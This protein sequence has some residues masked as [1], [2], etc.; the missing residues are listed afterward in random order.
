MRRPRWSGTC[1][2]ISTGM[3]AGIRR[4]QPARSSGPRRPTRSA[5]SAASSSRT[6][7]SCASNC[8]RCPIS[9]RPSAIACS[10]RRSRCSTTW[11]M[12]VCFPSPMETAPSGNGNRGSRRGPTIGKTSRRWWRNRSIRRDSRPS[13]ATSRRP[14]E[15]GG[16]PMPVTVRTFA[17]SG[18]AAAALSSD[19]GARY[20]GG[21]TL[22]M[23]ALNEG[24]VPISNVVRVQNSN[25]KQNRAPGGRVT[26]G[27]GVTLA[28]ILAERELAF[29]HATA[30]SIGG[31]AVRNMGT[32]GG[33]LFAP[34]PYGDFTVALLALDAVV[35]VQGG[36][37]SRA[38]PIEEF[39]QSR[40][41]QTDTLVLSVSCQKPGSAEA[42]RYRKI[43][44]IKPKGGSVIPLAPHLPMS[45]G[46][47]VGARI[48]LGSMAP[49]QIRARAAERAL[50]GRSLDAS[51][52]GAAA[53]A[54][55]EGTSPGDSALASAW[56]QREIV[57][58]H[59]RRLLSGQE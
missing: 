3:I 13:A 32:V 34:N 20:L 22:V 59:L 38:V 25:L 10:I 6:A 9:S 41:R 26:I 49:T 48:A 46:R 18:E 24:D 17:S 43:A 12:S 15:R 35:S 31:P 40:E 47:I 7:R 23:R 16:K 44:R 57:G 53:A 36:L 29:L 42:F 19:R 8:W 1:C 33:N 45:S 28:Q 21:G 55:V 51:T 2:A 56:Y 14:H 30:R 27:A 39:L 50:E 5:A 52:I 58:V 11:R 54:A 37:G 4:W